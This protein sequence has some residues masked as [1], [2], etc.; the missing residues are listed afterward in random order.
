[1]CTWYGWTQRFSTTSGY[2]VV[3]CCMQYVD[4]TLPSLSHH[5]YSCGN[6]ES[7]VIWRSCWSCVCVWTLVVYIMLQAH[8]DFIAVV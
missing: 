6:T 4:S 3:P 1:M 5:H 8:L 7:Q 2:A